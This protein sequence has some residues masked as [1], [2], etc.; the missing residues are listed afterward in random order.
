VSFSSHTN[1]TV[2]TSGRNPTT[3]ISTA[4]G[5]NN[6]FIK[7]KHRRHFVP[8][9]RTV[10]LVCCEQFVAAAARNEK[11]ESKYL[12]CKPIVIG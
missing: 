11:Y 12:M 10:A 8:A 3:L 4:K 1:V 7:V 2:L 5:L 9:G 6:F